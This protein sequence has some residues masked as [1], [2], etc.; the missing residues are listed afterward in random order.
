MVFLTTVMLALAFDLIGQQTG[1][2]LALRVFDTLV[3]SAIGLAVSAPVLPTRTGD[4]IREGTI[5]FLDELKDHLHDR[6]D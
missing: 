4:K 5:D 6:I 1:G 3:G 2:I